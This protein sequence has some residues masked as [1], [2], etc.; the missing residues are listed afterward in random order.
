MERWVGR[1]TVL[2]LGSSVNAFGRTWLPPDCCQL[3]NSLEYSTA[4][5]C[6]ADL[7]IVEQTH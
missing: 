1:C 3:P 6:T 2:Q 4:M 5:D 7:M